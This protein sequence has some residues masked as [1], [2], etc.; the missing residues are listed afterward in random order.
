MVYTKELSYTIFHCTFVYKANT[1]KEVLFLAINNDCME[2]L[3]SNV[4]MLFT[5]SNINTIYFVCLC[6]K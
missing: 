5:V 3:Y 2:S 6:D 1:V 4:S